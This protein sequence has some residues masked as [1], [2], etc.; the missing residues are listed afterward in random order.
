VVDTFGF[1]LMSFLRTEGERFWDMIS[2]ALLIHANLRVRVSSSR[3]TEDGDFGCGGG[4]SFSGSIFLDGLLRD[5]KADLFEKELDDPARKASS[6]LLCC[7][8]VT[9]EALM[10]RINAEGSILD[11]CWLGGEEV[12]WFRRIPMMA[13]DSL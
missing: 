13:E 8:R 12:L 3:E 4:E 1:D 5:S 10:A 6:K 11:I 7:P 9:C 2:F